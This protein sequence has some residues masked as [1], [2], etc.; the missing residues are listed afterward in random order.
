[1]GHISQ[2]TEV[3]GGGRAGRAGE[4][5]RVAGALGQ[6]VGVLGELPWLLGSKARA[7]PS[8]SG[9]QSLAVGKGD[10]VWGKKPQKLTLG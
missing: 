8:L 3:Q 9:H 7:Q 6:C 4:K 10:Q 2:L 1:M 5:S